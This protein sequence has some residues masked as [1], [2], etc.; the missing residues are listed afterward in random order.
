MERNYHEKYDS[1]AH[2]VGNPLGGVHGADGD[3]CVPAGERHPCAGIAH[4]GNPAQQAQGHG[5]HIPSPRQIFRRQR[6]LF[7]RPP[8]RHR[9]PQPKN[10]YEARA[11]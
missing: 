7:P 8:E 9:H 3:L 1:N 4:S 5:G 11:R 10:R 6:P 2:H